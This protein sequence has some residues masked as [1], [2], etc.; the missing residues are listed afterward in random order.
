M[1]SPM[2]RRARLKAATYATFGEAANWISG[3][4]GQP[5]PVTIIAADEEEIVRFGDSQ[6]IVGTLLYKVRHAE[7]PDPQINDLCVLTRTGEN[8][9]VVG[10]PIRVKYG[11]DWLCWMA[12]AL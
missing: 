9:R 11:L 10:E 8:F 6:A 4:G 1:A 12:E 5:R 2:D 3:L 7:V